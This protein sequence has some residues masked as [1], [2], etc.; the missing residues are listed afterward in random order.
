MYTEGLHI[1]HNA[2]YITQKNQS[3]PSNKK[4]AQSN[5]SSISPDTKQKKNLPL[6]ASFKDD[7]AAILLLLSLTSDQ[8]PRIQAPKFAMP[9]RGFNSYS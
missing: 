7:I 4:L 1:T 3:I 2:D 8:Y 6:Q 5:L 9:L